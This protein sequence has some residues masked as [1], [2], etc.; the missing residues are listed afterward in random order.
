MD[1]HSGGVFR[2]APLGLNQVL[3]GYSGRGALG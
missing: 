1:F 3:R 2:A